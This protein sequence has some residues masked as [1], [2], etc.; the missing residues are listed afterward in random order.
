M[1]YKSLKWKNRDQLIEA[2]SWWLAVNSA[3]GNFFDG[4]S[5]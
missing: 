1:E 5:Y 4:L 2:D 3:L